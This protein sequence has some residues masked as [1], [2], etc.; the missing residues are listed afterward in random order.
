M[1]SLFNGGKLDPM[2]LQVLEYEERRSDLERVVR[3]IKHNYTTGMIDV[4]DIA[5]ECGVYNLSDAE[6]GYIVSKLK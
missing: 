3:F 5:A 1:F 6:F 4:D 2:S